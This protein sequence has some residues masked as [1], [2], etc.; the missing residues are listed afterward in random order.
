MSTHEGK[1]DV[2]VVKIAI[3]IHHLLRQNPTSALV[4]PQQRTFGL[5][6]NG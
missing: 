3:D 6:L 5:L 2:H 4:L 1:E